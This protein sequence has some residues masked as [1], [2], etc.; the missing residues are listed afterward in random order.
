MKSSIKK[1]YE[2][3]KA[4]KQDATVETVI[5]SVAEII[6]NYEQGRINITPEYQRAY[7]WS[8]EKKSRFIE[9]LI[10]GMPVPAIFAI[11]EEDEDYNLK[12]EIIDGLQRISTILEF[13]GKLKD[14]K[15]SEKL[16]KIEG[17]DILF[18]LNGLSWNDIEKT[19]LGFI[20]ESSTL[21]FMNLKTLKSQIKYETFKRLNTGG[22][23]LEPQEIR[24]NILSLRGN[25]KYKELIERYDKIELDF[26]PA[27]YKKDRKDMELFLEFSLISEYEEFI[28]IFN[29]KEEKNNDKKTFE[30][31]L[32][33]YV[34]Y[35][36]IEKLINVLE[37]YEEFLKLCKKFKFRRYDKEKQE[38]TGAFI[39]QYFE[40]ASFIYFKNKDY[41][42][43]EN[44]EKIFNK[45]YEQFYRLRGL[46]NPAALRRLEEAHKYV[47]ELLNG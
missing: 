3:W 44:L 30:L 12:Y 6:R 34:E 45:T 9:S 13:V 8:N 29:K 11:K 33:D 40:I 32:D 23:K 47:E 42:I 15:N 16:K 2:S 4:K 46:N 19:N 25:K 36:E 21:L 28:E 43:E 38:N 37:N 20:F 1:I 10:L 5:L 17:T 18:E 24:S 7:K 41:L 26:L 39:N 31:L 27:K 35:V 22:I 14:N